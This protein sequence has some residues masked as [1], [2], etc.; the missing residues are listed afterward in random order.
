MGRKVDAAD[1][2]ANAAC[3]AGVGRSRRDRDANG[4][5]ILNCRA[6]V[7]THRRRDSAGI[8]VLTGIQ[9]RPV[10]TRGDI[11]LAAL[12]PLHFLHVG[13]LRGFAAHA[14]TNHRKAALVADNAASLH[15]SA[16]AALQVAIGFDIDRR[17]ALHIDVV[18][19]GAADCKKP[20]YAGRE[21]GANSH[22]AEECLAPRAALLSHHGA[23]ESRLL[24]SD[25]SMQPSLFREWR[26]L[27]PVLNGTLIVAERVA[28]DV[29]I[30]EP[31][32]G[33]LLQQLDSAEGTVIH[34]ILHHNVTGPWVRLQ[35]RLQRS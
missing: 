18:A 22:N 9:N 7:D 14:T 33:D 2:T 13:V 23:L 28:Q 6:D 1:G 26:K 19:F 3:D 30:D 12:P 16:L 34:S 15:A 5:S 20:D 8:Q 25:V 11:G 27:V 29:R 35:P 32:G 10:L 24:S 21:Q 4:A 17:L 31:M